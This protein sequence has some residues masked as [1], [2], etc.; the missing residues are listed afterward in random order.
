MVISILSTLNKHKEMTNQHGIFHVR[1]LAFLAP[2][3]QWTRLCCTPPGA[4]SQDSKVSEKHGLYS[5]E[6]THVE[7]WLV[8]GLLILLWYVSF[9]FKLI[10]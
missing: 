8:M 4:G 6:I 10:I 5:W 1:E 9:F 2:P 3:R 7:F